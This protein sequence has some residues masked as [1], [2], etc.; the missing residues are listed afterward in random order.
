MATAS[1]ALRIWDTKGKLISEGDSKDFLWGVS[2][3]KKGNRI[4]TSSLEQR[5]V[6]W[7]NKAE[8]LLSIE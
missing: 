2:W 4:I 5:I 3:N 1:D 6:L 7:N 8:K